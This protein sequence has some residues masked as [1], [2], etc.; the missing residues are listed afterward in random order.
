MMR[1]HI[2]FLSGAGVSAESGLST[3]RGKDGMWTNKEWVYLAS[4]E[5]LNNDIQRCLDFYNYRRKQLAE[6]SSNDAHRMIAE[7]EKDFDVT[8][9]TQNVDNLHERAGSTNVIHIHGELSKVCSMKDRTQCVKE[10]PLTTPIKI[11]DKGEDGAQIRPYIVMFGEKVDNI[12]EAV[13]SISCAD[14]FVIIG[15][16]LKIYPAARF[17]AFVPRKAKKY[18]IDPN[19]IR[20]CTTLGYEHIKTNA[21][22]GMRLLTETLRKL[23]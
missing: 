6:V 7:L 19:E 9:V 3:F 10:Y 12:E 14:I 2:V 5:A 20:E 17:T 15:T 21:T 4:T 13:E 22:E 23:Q 18:V 1:R 16:S 11:G 8:I